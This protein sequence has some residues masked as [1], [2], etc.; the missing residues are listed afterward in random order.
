M[1]SVGI[2]LD[3][4]AAALSGDYAGIRATPFGHAFNVLSYLGRDLKGHLDAPKPTGQLGGG[5]LL[6]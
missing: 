2:A 1:P 3:H 6:F 5:A 4:T